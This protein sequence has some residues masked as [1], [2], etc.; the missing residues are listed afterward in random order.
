M[1]KCS[2]QYTRQQYSELAA[3]SVLYNSQHTKHHK[4]QYKKQI[5]GLHAYKR[6]YNEV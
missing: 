4:L 2:S 1:V 3:L 6:A 5:P